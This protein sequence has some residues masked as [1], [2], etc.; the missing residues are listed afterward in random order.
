MKSFF[1]TSTTLPMKGS[2]CSLGYINSI[3]TEICKVLGW[4]GNPR[5]VY[6]RE[7]TFPQANTGELGICKR[8]FPRKKLSEKDIQD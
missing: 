2:N 3:L 8:R 5:D 7:I 6:P 1:T 4:N